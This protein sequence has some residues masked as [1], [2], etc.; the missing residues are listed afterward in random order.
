[1]SIYPLAWVYVL[2]RG[3]H[4]DEIG[5]VILGSRSR[6]GLLWEACFRCWR[7]R[8]RRRASDWWWWGEYWCWVGWVG[9]WS[10]YLLGV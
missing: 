6:I 1:V 5:V 2:C 4:A 3:D 8:V 7:W 10:G 9:G